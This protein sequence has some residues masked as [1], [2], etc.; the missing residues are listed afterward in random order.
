MSSFFTTAYKGNVPGPDGVIVKVTRALDKAKFERSSS[1]SLFGRR[2]FPV[3]EAG[4]FLISLFA[5]I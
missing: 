3:G 5:A 4:G 1:N 2:L